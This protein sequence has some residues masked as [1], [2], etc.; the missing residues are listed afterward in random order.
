MKRKAWHKKIENILSEYGKWSAHCDN[1]EKWPIP[2]K[3]RMFQEKALR[4][5][6]KIVE[7]L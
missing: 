7:T 4:E 3:T 2:P 5:I 1:E 6:I